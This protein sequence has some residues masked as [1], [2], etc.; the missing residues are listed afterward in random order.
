M[1]NKRKEIELINYEGPV[2]KLCKSD[3]DFVIYDQWDGIVDILNLSKFLRFLDGDLTLMD[4]SGR[5]WNWKEH[6]KEAK[7][8][9]SVIIKYA[10]I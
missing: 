9:I 7:Q 4:G 8:K 1:R 2:L 5:H 6:P 10:F 3:E